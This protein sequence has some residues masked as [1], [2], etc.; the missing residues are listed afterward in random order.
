MFTEDDAPK[1]QP[2]CRT[3]LTRRAWLRAAEGHLASLRLREGFV[4]VEQQKKA[5]IEYANRNYTQ[6]LASTPRP[7]DQT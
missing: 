6:L 7:T 1:H 2:A 4:S 5:A 3:D